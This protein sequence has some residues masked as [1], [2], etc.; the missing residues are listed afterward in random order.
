M[1]LLLVFVL[2][3][4]WC[5][6]DAMVFVQSVGFFRDQRHSDL[7]FHHVALKL[8][9]QTWVSAVPRGLNG[10]I[11]HFP[12]LETLE[13]HLHYRLVKAV[14]LPRPVAMDLEAWQSR[15]LVFDPLCLWSDQNKTHCSKFVGQVLGIAP[16]AMNFDSPVWRDIKKLR[17]LPVGEVGLSPDKIHEHLI[18]SCEAVLL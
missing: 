11:G 15:H 5:L 17:H 13:G 16:S 2:V 10:P 7:M 4:S 14:D 12:N 18:R 9:D 6:A 8:D 3:S 1:Q